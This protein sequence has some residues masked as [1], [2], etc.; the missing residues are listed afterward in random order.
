MPKRNI[1]IDGQS[2]TLDARPDRLDLRDFPYRPPVEN[3]PGQFP[4]NP[5]V[6]QSLP[7]YL[8]AGLILDQGKEGACTGY[9]LAAVMNYLLWAQSGMQMGRKDRVSP[10]MLYHLARFYDEWPGENYEGSSCRGA[11]KGWHKHGACLETLWPTDPEKPER[12]V[13]PKDNWDSDAVTR[14]L[15]TYYRI[16][17]QSVVDMQSAIRHTGAIYVSGMVHKGWSVK[18]KKGKL[19]HETLP[20]IRPNSQTL[21]G[22]A[23]ALV[24]YN[25]TGFI[26]Q[27]SWGPDWGASGF[28]VLTYEDWVDNGSDAWVVGL[29]VPVR[30]GVRGS[31]KGA[32][33]T[34][35]KHYVHSKTIIQVGLPG[36]LGGDTP[37]ANKPYAWSADMAYA[38]TLVTGND[39]HIINRLPHVENEKAAAR[40]VCYKQPTEWFT[41]TNAAGPK[42][43]VI[44]AHGG[45]NDEAESIQRIRVMAPYFAENGI[46]PIFVTWKSGW[47]ETL[48]NML[49]D[50]ASK[51]LGSAT[52]PTRGIGDAIKEAWDR[53]IELLARSVLAGSLWREMKE[54]VE[55]AADT[56]RALCEL[57]DQL[58]ALKHDHGDLEIHLVGHSA[59]SFICGTLLKQLEGEPIASCTLY[60]PACDLEFAL[61]H[62]KPAIE[63]NSLKRND[64]R[65]HLLSHARE[66]DDAVGPYRKSLL[67]L[68]SRALERR[69]KTPLLGLI[70]AFDGDMDNDGCWH[71]DTVQSV[72]DW[73]SFFWNGAAPTGLMESGQSAP[74]ANLF[75]LNDKQISAGPRRIKATHGCFDNAVQIVEGTIRTI[76]GVGPSEN[77]KKEVKDLDF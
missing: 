1:I 66:L 50:S 69:H 22:H 29:G 60:A 11:L 16:D 9:G 25:D 5:Q 75:V 48:A 15:G 51:E 30:Q 3:L 45:L 39:G 8:E 24:G 77:L 58:K 12:F 70:G 63:S 41:K 62:F 2:L 54:N 32:P 20:V 57:G 67:Y 73:Q 55:C 44:Y 27:N 6:Q 10:R 72:K 7:A 65:I 59:G 49:T 56:G 35:P 13:E 52:P 34:S 43:I 53:S 33:I 71:N 26:V 47:Q 4:A 74:G 42:R 61:K 19:T 68:V 40:Y 76:L 31:A 28:A 18:Q 37:L 23:F 36:W 38:H 17:R 46:Y 21:G 64:F 14:P